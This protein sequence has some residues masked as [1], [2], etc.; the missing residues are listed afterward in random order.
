[1]PR[2]VGSGALY[3]STPLCVVLFL[4][5][6]PTLQCVCCHSVV[7]LGVCLCGRVVSLWNSGDGLRWGGMAMVVRGV[8]LVPLPPRLSSFV[9]VFGVV[10]AQPR[11]HARYP[12]T[13]LCS[14][15]CS[16]FSFFSFFS[17]SFC[18]RLSTPR[19]SSVMEWRC[20]C[21]PCVGVF[22]GHDGDG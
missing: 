11:E 7:G 20:A 6:R 10:R 2:L 14:P 12:R 13:P 19:L 21:S 16:V 3:C 8:C 22:G 4:L 9:L 15:C 17:L 18:G 1:M 5:H